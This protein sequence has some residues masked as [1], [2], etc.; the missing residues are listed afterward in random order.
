MDRSS[1]CRPPQ[2]PRC[3]NRVRPD[4]VTRG[5]PAAAW[6]PAGSGGSGA[7]E[8]IQGLTGDRDRIAQRLNKVVV[9]RLFAAG[10]GLHA[11]VGLVGDHP[12]ASGID[13]A[14]GDWTRSS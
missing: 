11:A 2:R 10:L 13:R 9:H 4:A 3:Q 5:P 7:A 12:G 14:I 1:D 8:E 6:A